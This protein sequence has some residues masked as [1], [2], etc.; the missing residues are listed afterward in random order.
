MISGNWCLYERRSNRFIFGRRKQVL[1]APL[2]A[3]L[4][5]TML[6]AVVHYL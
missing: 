3:A 5:V 1:G 6:A 4:A 2:Y